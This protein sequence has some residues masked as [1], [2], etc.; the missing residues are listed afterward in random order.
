MGSWTVAQRTMS[1]GKT[2]LGLAISVKALAPA[3]DG[4]GT[5]AGG[6]SSVPATAQA[7]FQPSLPG[8]GDS[9]S[10]RWQ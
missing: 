6:F 2:L 1:I 4:L 7:S 5:R 3:A 9:L 10:R 8:V